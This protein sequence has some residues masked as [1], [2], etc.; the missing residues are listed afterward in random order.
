MTVGLIMKRL[1]TFFCLAL[2][3]GTPAA[4]N[5]DQLKEGTAAFKAGNY[6]K[7]LELFKPLAEQG[8]VNA[9]Y[10]LGLMYMAGQGVPE[11]HVLAHKWFNLSASRSKGTDHEEAVRLRDLIG[12]TMT[13]AQVGQAQKLA[14]EWKPK[15]NKSP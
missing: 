9:Q 3:V 6:Q 4:V 1:I 14:R 7:A 2:L 15:S 5:A 13:P 8:D 10:N 12:K 11:D